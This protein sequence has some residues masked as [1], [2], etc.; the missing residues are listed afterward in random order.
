[1]NAQKNAQIEN[2]YQDMLTVSTNKLN[3]QDDKY[4]K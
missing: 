4:D 1:M 3:A 2:A